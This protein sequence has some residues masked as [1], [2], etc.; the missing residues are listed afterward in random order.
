METKSIKVIRSDGRIRR[1]HVS[2]DTRL[3]MKAL[4]TI[5]GGEIEVVALPG[6]RHMVIHAEGKIERLPA[7]PIATKLAHD[8][9]S[10]QTND[11]I[12]GTAILAPKML[13]L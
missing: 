4:Q 6:S 9:E 12:A 1:A 2:A 7:N 5:I 11:Y 13:F 3:S 10:I 8:A